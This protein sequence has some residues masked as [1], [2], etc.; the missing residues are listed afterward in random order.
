MRAANSW[1]MDEKADLVQLD[2]GHI[3]VMVY[4]SGFQR[5]HG[6][7]KGDTEKS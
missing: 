7:Q 4:Y 2:V 6:T 1:P 5:E 3:V